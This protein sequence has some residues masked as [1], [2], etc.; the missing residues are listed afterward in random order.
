MIIKGTRLKVADNSGAKIAECI[1]LYGGGVV[2]WAHAAGTIMVVI[3]S[4]TPNAK[5]E[6][7]QKHK[8]IIVRTKS[9]IRRNDGSYV[10]FG[11]NAVVLID[12]KGEPIGSR[13]FGAVAREIRDSG[14]LKIASLANEVL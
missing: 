14:Y 13:V 9:T 1:G 2:R 6:K 12:K 3:K 7:S 5:V 8:A 11:D 10:T 4:A